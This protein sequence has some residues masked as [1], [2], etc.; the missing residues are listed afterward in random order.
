MKKL[1]FFALVPFLFSGCY[2][3]MIDSGEVGVQINSGVVQE[4]PT[5]RVRHRHSMGQQSNRSYYT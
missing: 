3:T 5:Q 2:M 1:L 4:N